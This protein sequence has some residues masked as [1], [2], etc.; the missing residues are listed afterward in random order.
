[1]FN[2]V[3]QILNLLEGI[4]GTECFLDIDLEGTITITISKTKINPVEIPDTYLSLD[5]EKLEA[6]DELND[7]V[8]KLAERV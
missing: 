8:S 5:D 4:N 6:I 1:M 3:N 7:F 2:K